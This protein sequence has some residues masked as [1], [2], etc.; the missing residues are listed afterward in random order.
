MPTASGQGAFLQPIVNLDRGPLLF[1]C[2]G[3]GLALDFALRK[4]DLLPAVAACVRPLKL[5]RENLLG[6]TTVVA[7][8]HEGLEIFKLL[9]ART[10]FRRG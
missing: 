2:G 6:L 9:E 4:F 8:A 5:V 10:M 1:W 7:A 3:F